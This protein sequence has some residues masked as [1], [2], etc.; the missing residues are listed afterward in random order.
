MFIIRHKKWFLLIGALIIA[1]AAVIVAVFGVKPGLDFTGGSLMEVRYETLPDR[2][3]VEAATQALSFGEVAIRQSVS[4][5]GQSFLVTTRDLTDEERV[6]LESAM[7]SLG[8]GGEVARFTS[9]GP[10]I[11]AELADKAVWALGAVVFLIVC[12]VAFAFA[13][14][15]KPVSSW[16]YGFTAIG[17]LGH[18]VLLPLAAMSLL[19]VF[20]GVEADVLFVTA[21]LTILG[22][23]VNDTIVIF[24][25][26]REKLKQNR[27]EQRHKVQV[28]GGMP[29]EEV[30]YTLTRPFDELVGEAVSETMGRSL[31]TSVAV[32]LVLLALYLFG[33]ETMQVFTLIL[34]V[35][36]VAGTYSSIFIA[37]PLLV[38]YEAWRR[39]RAVAPADGAK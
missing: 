1:I 7:T 11:G 39:G 29:R 24:D 14:I 15:G 6:A 37:T 20:L 36:V 12:Y 5:D 27:T 33:G 17:V 22:Y 13:G 10:V 4:D 38:A 31:N 32:F 19:G 3:A 16:I 35:G 9:V 30:T 23:S 28:V 34:M 8:T 26:V 2:A 18:D 21:L 25:R